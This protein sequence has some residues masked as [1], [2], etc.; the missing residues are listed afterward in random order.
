M[1]F[2]AGCRGA[3]GS[4]RLPTAMRWGLVMLVVVNLANTNICKSHEKMPETLAHWFSSKSTQR[5]LS[6][7]YQPDRA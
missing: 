6:N 4:D 3:E 5:K 1:A 7:E 2:L